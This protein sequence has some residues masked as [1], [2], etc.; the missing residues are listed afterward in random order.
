TSV[1]L[2]VWNTSIVDY[3]AK[4]RMEKWLQPKFIVGAIKDLPFPSL[5]ESQQ[6]TLSENSI[7]IAK[8]K[9]W[10]SSCDETSRYANELLSFLHKSDTLSLAT[11]ANLAHV[12]ALREKILQW[13]QEID[14]TVLQAF[15]L[16]ENSD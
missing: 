3:L 10:V 2:G 5:S 13:H 6:Q 4:L 11:R 7:N 16:A 8:A 15:E 14:N 1:V 12:N 9:C